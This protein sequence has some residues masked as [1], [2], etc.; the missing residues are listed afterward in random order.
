MSNQNT[1][2][3]YRKMYKWIDREGFVS[4]KNV[5][6]NEKMMIIVIIVGGI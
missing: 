1:R 4:N 2:N 6:I 3:K 5:Q